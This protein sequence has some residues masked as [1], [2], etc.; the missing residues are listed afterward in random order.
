MTNYVE[1][2]TWWRIHGKCSGKIARGDIN[3]GFLRHFCKA[4]SWHAQ[5]YTL[6]SSLLKYGKLSFKE[7][8][9]PTAP[10]P[11]VH[12]R[13]ATLRGLRPVYTLELGQIG[14][15]WKKW[16]T[17]SLTDWQAAPNDLLDDLIVPWFE[18]HSSFSTEVYSCLKGLNRWRRF[19]KI[20][21]QTWL[22]VK[23]VI[24]INYFWECTKR[25]NRFECK[26]IITEVYGG[27]YCVQF[28]PPVDCEWVNNRQIP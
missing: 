5:K 10:S 19:E 22:E 3:L 11:L 13:P 9:D 24:L 7:L 15:Q 14:G 27:L 20:N 25:W 26:L 21:K 1:T 17:H 12:V 16:R 6:K 2:V 28:H 18:I 4:K 8:G 23:T